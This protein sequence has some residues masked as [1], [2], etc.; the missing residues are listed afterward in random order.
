VTSSKED[1]R[2]WESEKLQN[3]FFTHY[4]INALQQGQEPPTIHQVFE[5]LSREVPAA[6]AREKNAPQN[7]QLLPRDGTE[8]LRIGVIPRSVATN[9]ENR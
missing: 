3:G 1:E 7:P 6:V 5:Y 8:D 2:S 4:L 9:N